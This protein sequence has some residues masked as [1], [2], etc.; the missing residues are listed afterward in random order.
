MPLTVG[1]HPPASETPFLWRFAG[2]PM[3]AHHLM[4]DW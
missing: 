3:M 2:V 4:M 1:H